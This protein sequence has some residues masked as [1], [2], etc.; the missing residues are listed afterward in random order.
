D[1]MP[2]VL[3]FAIEPSDW[4][5]PC[6]E[7]E[8]VD[9]A[10][11]DPIAAEV[12]VAVTFGV[13]LTRL[14]ALLVARLASGLWTSL[15]PRLVMVRALNTLNALVVPPLFVQ[16]PPASVASCNGLTVGPAYDVPGPW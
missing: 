15:K 7:K 12:V 11:G 2:A 1:V 10:N 6:S 13:R 9:G 14:G 4:V 3:E 8:P 5:G 16:A